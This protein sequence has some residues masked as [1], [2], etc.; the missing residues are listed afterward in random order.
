[1]TSET[2]SKWKSLVSQIWY[3]KEKI[4]L[5]CSR[6][7]IETI[8]PECQ[9]IYFQPQMRRCIS[10][11][12]LIA[13]QGT[14]CKD[15]L[16]GI[17]PKGLMKVVTLGYYENAWR[18]LICNVKFKS[19]PY[20]LLGISDCLTE[21]AM[22]NLPPPDAVVPVPIH[23]HKL[24]ERGFNQAEIIASILSNHLGIP[25]KNYIL[26]TK[27]TLPQTSLGRKERIENL[28]GAFEIK[29]KVMKDEII[30]LADDVT[31]TGATL[32][33]CAQILKTNGVKEVYGVCLGAGKEE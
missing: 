1:M 11:G 25:I 4:C 12:K 23:P 6:K 3:E 31:T 26:R 17:G 19:Q 27:N 10:C 14:Q 8:C 16:S 5:L 15:C 18:E 28:H 2:F 22:K 13:N 21:L 30:W 9:E 7:S 24:A 33:E 20:L 29:E 32:E